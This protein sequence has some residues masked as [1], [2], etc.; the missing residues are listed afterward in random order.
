VFA[1]AVTEAR[2]AAIQKA[3]LERVIK[4][5][6]EFALRLFHSLSELLR[7]SDEVIESLSHREVST[8]LATLLVNLWASASATTPTRTCS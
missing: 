7:Q 6:P 8:R 1:E 3:S 5:N 4:S 2:V